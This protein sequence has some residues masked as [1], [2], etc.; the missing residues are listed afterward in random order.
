MT[1]LSCKIK[2]YSG[3]SACPVAGTMTINRCL[4]N[5]SCFRETRD[6]HSGKDISASMYF[7]V[8]FECQQSLSIWDK[9]K[10]WGKLW[11]II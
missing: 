5:E 1:T 7:N 3:G 9:K 2:Q 8:F 11:E 4:V 6:L 10:E